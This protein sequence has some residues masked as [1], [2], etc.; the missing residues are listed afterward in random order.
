ML[1]DGI[2]LCLSVQD[3]PGKNIVA[4]VCNSKVVILYTKLTCPSNLDPLKPNFYIVKLRFTW[5]YIIFPN[6]LHIDGRCGYSVI[7]ITSL[8]SSHEYSKSMF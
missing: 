1:F 7:R 3:V 8:S 4:I 6:F 5:V 2:S